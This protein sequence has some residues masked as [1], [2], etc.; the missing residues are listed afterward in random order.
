MTG[1][2]GVFLYF[3][4]VVLV[5]ASETMEL[6]CNR[7]EP[8]HFMVS[9]C[10]EGWP[11]STVC[12]ICKDGTF[13]PTDNNDTS[14]MNC[15][16]PNHVVYSED[17]TPVACRCAKGFH[18]RHSTCLRNPFCRPGKGIHKGGCQS[19]PDGQFSDRYSNIQHCRPLTNCTALGMTTSLMGT[20]RR[21][22]ICINTSAATGRPRHHRKNAKEEETG[23][24]SHGAQNA[25]LMKSD[26]RVLKQRWESSTAY[27]ST[28]TV[29]KTPKNI[30]DATRRTTVS[31]SAMYK[32]DMT[33]YLIIG[34]TASVF[35]LIVVVVSFH[36]RLQHIGMKSK[37]LKRK[38]TCDAVQEDGKTS[39]HDSVR[40]QLFE[41]PEVSTSPKETEARANEPP[42]YHSQELQVQAMNHCSID[43]SETRDEGYR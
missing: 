25:V 4:V 29:A 2:L 13:S 30:E 41:C 42:P 26:R 19:C 9:P 32:I 18:K 6:E 11:N 39:C 12:E 15:L 8:G 27:T 10:T 37:E 35:I 5:Q 31:E 7:C 40:S 36:I 3:M 28:K 17:D 43:S 14:C 22:T 23:S 21:D 38:V 20:S 24:G 34:V 33:D 16:E 1:R